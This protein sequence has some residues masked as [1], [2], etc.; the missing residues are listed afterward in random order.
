MKTKYKY[1][2]FRKDKA[3]EYTCFTNDDNHYL[4]GYVEW[5][6]RWRQYVFVTVADTMHTPSCLDDIA[7]FI[8]QMPR[9]SS[10]TKG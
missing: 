10:K 5:S 8:R 7:H 2:Y 4:L 9:K 1:I 6:H 3:G